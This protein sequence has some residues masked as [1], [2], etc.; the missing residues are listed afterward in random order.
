MDVDPDEEEKLNKEIKI[1]MREY[2]EIKKVT[3][4]DIYI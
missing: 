2:A 4:N 1:L 3:I